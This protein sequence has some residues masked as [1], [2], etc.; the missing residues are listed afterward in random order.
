[1][2]LFTNISLISVTRRLCL[3]GVMG[4]FANQCLSASY[5]IG[6]EDINY[7]PYFDYTSANP[8]FSK[9][10]F[11]QFA[12]DS[13]HQISFLPLPIKQFDKWLF[14]ENIDFKFPDNPRWQQQP[15]SKEHT[16]YFS[17]DILLMTA[18]TLILSKNKDKPESFIKNIGTIL[19]FQP[20]LWMEQIAQGKVKVIEDRSSKILVKQLVHG[21]VDGLDIDLAVANHHLI[22]L[23]LNNEIVVSQNANRQVFAYTLSTLKFPQI[24]QQF[25][26]WLAEN[27][28]FVTELKARYNILAVEPNLKDINQ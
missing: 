14:E 1:L 16:L 11:V 17:D 9:D 13:G 8:S 4:L 26:V 25:N 6:V 7:Y 12:A 20:T 5:I 3:I 21:I 23:K 27:K 15:V 18:G 19:G 10:L 22:E 28:T 24:I 2:I